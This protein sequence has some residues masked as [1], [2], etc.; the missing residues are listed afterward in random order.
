MNVDDRRSY[1]PHEYCDSAGDD[2]DSVGYGDDALVAAAAAA[3]AAVADDAHIYY[4]QPPSCIFGVLHYHSSCHS[5]AD[6]D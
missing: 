3:A 4:V 1:E 6:L 5:A 2:D